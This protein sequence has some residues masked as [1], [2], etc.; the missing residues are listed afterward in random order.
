MQEENKNNHE[1][2]EICFSE[3]RYRRLFEAARDGILI[4]DAKSGAIIDVN[5]YLLGK[6]E[7][8]KEELLNK[9]L[10]EI[11]PFKDIFASK[12]SFKELQNKEYIR[13]DDLPLETKNGKKIEFEFV[14]NVYME[15]QRKVIQCNIRDNSARKAAEKLTLKLHEQQEELE[16]QL[17]S[18]N[19]QLN[20]VINVISYPVF[21][22]DENSVFLF[23][24]DAFC[25]MLGI[26]QENIIGKT[27]AE[28]L[29][30]DQMEHFFKIDKLVIESGQENTCEEM[31]TGKDGK[32][33]TIITKKSRYINEQGE[34][35][36]VGVIQ[37]VT[38]HKILEEKLLQSRKMESIGTLAGGIAH[39]FNNL[40]TVIRGNVYLAQKKSGKAT[41]A[42][43]EHDEIVKAVDRAAELTKQLLLFSRQKHVKT[44]NLNLNDIV[45]NTMNMLRRLIGEDIKIEK[46]M[47]KDL[48]CIKADKTNIEQILLN[49]MM[50]ARDAM[51]DGGK[52]NVKTENVTLDASYLPKVLD[53][54]PGKFVKLSIQD[55][56]I[57]MSKEIIS[58]L[59]EPFFTTKNPGKGT[60]LGLSVVYGIV[61]QHKGW[62]N[63][64]SEPGKGSVFSIYFPAN[65]ETNA[66]IEKEIIETGDQRGNGERILI[67]EDEQGIRD[68]L[69]TL[70]T[71]NGYTVYP[72][73]NASEALELFI[74]EKNN[75]DVVL[76]DI[77]LPDR[78]GLE[79]VKGL[80]SFKPGLKVIFTSGYM[81]EKNQE[82]IIQN[83]GYEFIQK[84]YKLD[85]LF[86]IINKVLKK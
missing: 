31:L 48:W 54:Y 7:Y 40:L 30:E 66:G 21:V 49:L 75:F 6:L 2:Q 15:D 33:L 70:L 16:T 69:Q 27:L 57:G 13:Y 53:S 68:L 67:V 38:E 25:K 32:I 12:I 81:S 52:I 3:I 47:Q 39:D 37:D 46:N 17:Q 74:R 28:S 10:W 58:H 80:L 50:N 76:S 9:K 55:S 11:G 41:A 61:K 8:T 62:I 44:I 79:L 45:E 72:A 85:D 60:G 56:G 26:D 64:Y 83:S 63:I 1:N 65:L 78:N 86:L 35:I 51:P 36:L 24:N 14:S 71:D 20:S 5:P 34:N 59:F 73:A 77:I 82:E 18:F 4:L 84:P 29:P 43:V 42:S 23:V 22:K 19:K